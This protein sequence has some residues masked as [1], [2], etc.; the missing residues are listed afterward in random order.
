MFDSLLNLDMEILVFTSVL[1]LDLVG[2][3]CI[4]VIELSLIVLGCQ[5]DCGGPI[6]LFLI[7]ASVPQLV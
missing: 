1:N 7:P 6:D 2:A 3:G 5:I 4:S